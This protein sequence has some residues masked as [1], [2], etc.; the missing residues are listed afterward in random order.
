MSHNVVI[1]KFE[2]GDEEKVI[3]LLKEAAS[4]NLVGEE[5]V[6]CGVEVGL[7]DSKNIIRINE[8]PHA[9][10]VVMNF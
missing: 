7:V 1:R 3:S 10:A 5:A 8:V 4:A 2:E 9:Q 6:K